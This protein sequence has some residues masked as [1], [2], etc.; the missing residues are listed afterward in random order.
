MIKKVRVS[1]LLYVDED[2]GI[3]LNNPNNWSVGLLDTR[4][5]DLILD[6]HLQREGEASFRPKITIIN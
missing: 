4:R 5:D 6:V 2:R 3:D 1:M